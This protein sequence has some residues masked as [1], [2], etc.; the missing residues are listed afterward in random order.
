MLKKLK[1]KGVAMVE[2]AVLLAF[3]CG[4]GGLYMSDT[5]L[6]A[7]IDNTITK[8]VKLLEG[9]DFAGEDYATSFKNKLDGLFEDKL[10]ASGTKDENGDLP[11]G[12]ALV[13]GGNHFYVVEREFNKLS[14]DPATTTIEIINFLDKHPELQ[15]WL[16]TLPKSMEGLNN[17]KTYK[18]VS[19]KST[20][21][22]TGKKYEIQ[23]AYTEAKTINKN[24]YVLQ[25]GSRVLELPTTN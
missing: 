10:Y 3:V 18:V 22:Q 16:G 23:Y 2:Y 15:S 17:L 14:F 13:S 5:S 19:V 11:F 6:S 4:I 9:E 1:H 8:V 7:S 24:M 25:L 21:P 20:D 12:R